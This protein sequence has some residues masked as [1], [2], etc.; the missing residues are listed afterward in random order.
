MIS[1]YIRIAKYL[2]RRPS[3]D[4]TALLR[5]FQP[6]PFALS[7]SLYGKSSDFPLFNLVFNQILTDIEAC[8]KMMTSWVARSLRITADD[9][10]IEVEIIAEIARQRNLRIYELGILE[11]WAEGALVCFQIWLQVSEESRPGE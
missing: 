2:Q 1:K 8:C 4:G 3:A 10:G 5:P 6:T 9:F 11:G 7:S